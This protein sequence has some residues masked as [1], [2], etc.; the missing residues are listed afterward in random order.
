VSEANRFVAFLKRPQKI[1]SIL[2][3]SAR[4]I[5]GNSF[6][7]DY[8]RRFNP[9]VVMLPTSV[10]TARFMPRA[11]PRQSGA[12]LVVG[13][14]GTPTTTPYLEQMA[15]VFTQVA[16]AHPFTLRVSGAGHDVRIPGVEVENMPWSLDREVELFNTCDVGV[17]PLTDDEWSRGK[18]GFKAIQFMASGVPVVAAAVGVNCE[19]VEDGINGFLALTPAEWAVRLTRLLEDAV[20]RARFAAAGRTTIEARYSTHVNFPRLLA[21]FEDVLADRPSREVPPVHERTT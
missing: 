19:I 10:D 6:L 9:A 14:I 16:A 2:R 4:I 11:T 1:P 15:A 21:T 17:Y 3:R 13:W 7:A 18:C 5:A 12:P 20:L 8:A